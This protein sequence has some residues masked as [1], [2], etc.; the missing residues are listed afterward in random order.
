MNGT[1]SNDPTRGAG[2]PSLKRFGVAAFVWALA[3]GLL[4]GYWALGG[5]FGADQ[6][7]P[8]LREEAEH[9]ESG[10]VAIL[11]ITAA[12]KVIGGLIP[13]ALAYNRS[14]GISAR[15]LAILTWLGGGLLALYGLGDIL[16]ATLV[17]SGLMGMRDDST[18]WYLLLWG[19]IW[20]LGGVLFLGTA[21]VHRLTRRASPA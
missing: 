20:L 10:F 15:I 1:G 16:G 14:A 8:A 18:I 4:S 21:R 19:P 9:R 12:V 17:L 5:T 7:S 6:L 11:W 2:R 3:F 13:L